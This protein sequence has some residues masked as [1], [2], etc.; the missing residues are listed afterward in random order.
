MTIEPFSIAVP[1]SDLADLTERLA[2]TRWP[3]EVTGSNWHYGT[4][5]SYLQQ[6]CTY[7]KDS[8]DWR[9]QERY[10]NQWPQFTAK[11]DGYRVHFLH[12]RGKGPSPF[13]LV[14]THGWPGSFFEAHKILPLLTDPAAHGGDAADA[15]DV[16]APSLPGYGFSQIPTV[17]GYGPGKTAQ[18]WDGLMR[19]LGHGR[20]GAQGGDW[21]AVVTRNLGALFPERLAGI[22]MNMMVGGRPRSQDPAE[23]SDEEKAA[24]EQGRLWQEE[25]AGYQAIQRTKPQTLAYGLTDSPAGLAGWIVEKWRTWSD[26]NGDVESR[27]TK[28]EILTNISIYWHSGTINSSTRYYYEMAHDRQ[29][30]FPGGPVTVP[31]GFAAFP[32]EIGRG[33]RGWM[34]PYFNITHWAEFD[35]GGHFPAMEEPELLVGSIRE[36]FRPL[37]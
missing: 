12:A 23:L 26:C 15:F 21:G 36:F 33:Q 2:R 18:L 11:V 35:R 13:P 5:L 37:R 30:N 6:L 3:S 28:D 34:E 9:K 29:A 8:F 20:Y 14:F 10:L 27:F 24:V 32:K 31:T 25:E 19:Q 22:H 7:W 1:D 16:I 17:A 4:D